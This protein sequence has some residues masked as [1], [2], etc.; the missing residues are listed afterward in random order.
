MF[1]RAVLKLVEDGPWT[2]REA[3]DALRMEAQS[4]G[5]KARPTT[6]QRAFRSLYQKGLVHLRFRPVLTASAV[7]E[8][9]AV[10]AQARVLVTRPAQA[11]ASMS[12]EAPSRPLPIA[13]FPSG[14]P[15]SLT[16]GTCGSERALALRPAPVV[17]AA[18]RPAPVVAAALR[19]APAVEAALRPAPAVAAALR[20]SP[21][22]EVPARP[23]GFVLQTVI[24]AGPSIQPRHAGPR[25][26]P[27]A[28]E[29]A[30]AI[31]S[32]LP[33]RPEPESLPETPP[34]KSFWAQL[35]EARAES[36]K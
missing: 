34:K 16:Q 28:I 32:K 20:P 9:L 29:K 6:V 7:A 4:R 30:V 12:V 3:S 1:E 18:L 8:R 21:A 2:V 27:I 26:A 14:Q 23:V 10:P 11:R 13:R 25:P 33:K 31:L 36:R 15:L 17:A 5:L 24:P 35:A 22:V 19:P